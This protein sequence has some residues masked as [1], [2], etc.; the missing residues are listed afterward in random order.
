MEAYVCHYGADAWLGP[1]LDLQEKIVTHVLYFNTEWNEANGGCLKI[2]NSKSMED[3]VATILPVVGN[4]SVLVRSD[5]SWHA[6]SRV[7]KDAGESRRSMNVIFY[8]PGA[9]STMWPKGDT[10]PLHDYHG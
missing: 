2:L 6:V 9:E 10:P 8:R 5:C 3:D 1:H 4:S 7:R